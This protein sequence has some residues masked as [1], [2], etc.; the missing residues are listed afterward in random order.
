MHA[1]ERATS[2]LRL[3]DSRQRVRGVV[4]DQRELLLPYCTE[5]GVEY[6]AEL[7]VEL[8]VELCAELLQLA[9]LLQLERLRCQRDASQAGPG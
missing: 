8:C 3:G 1:K 7:G 5:L 9:L 4:A 2:E 6:C